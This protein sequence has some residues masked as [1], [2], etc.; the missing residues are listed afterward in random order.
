MNMD[1]AAVFLASSILTMLAAIVWV[2]AILV[3]N[4]LIHKYWKPIGL[5]KMID[6]NQRFAEP[7]EL[8]KIDKDKK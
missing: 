8:E 5:Y 1:V 4:N 7:R 3:I 2:M 6:P